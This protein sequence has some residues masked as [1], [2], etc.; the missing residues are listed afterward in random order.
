MRQRNSQP[1]PSR[2]FVSYASRDNDLEALKLLE[3]TMQ[4]IGDIYIDDI[5]HN[6]DRN[7]LIQVCVAL[8]RAQ[9][10]VA[11]SSKNYGSTKWTRRELRWAKILRIPI[12]TTEVGGGLSAIHNLGY[13][14]SGSWGGVDA[15]TRLHPN[16]DEPT[17]PSGTVHR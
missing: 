5:H 3:T 10:F 12:I 15:P 16:S 4:S 17:T 2:V 1:R 7:R 13:S 9:A 8:V 6:P 11:L 14:G